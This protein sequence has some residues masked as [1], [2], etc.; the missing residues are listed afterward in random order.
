MTCPVVTFETEQNPHCS[1][2]STTVPKLR[3]TWALVQ[4]MNTQLLPGSLDSPA[5]AQTV[6]SNIPSPARLLSRAHQA[7]GKQWAWHLD[8]WTQILGEILL[9]CLGCQLQ[10]SI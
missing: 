8:V 4:R 2:V 10:F 9:C 6:A 5:L 1:T 7:R 3:A